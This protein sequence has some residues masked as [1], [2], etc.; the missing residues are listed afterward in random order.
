MASGVIDGLK[1]YHLNLTARQMKKSKAMVE[2]ISRII[3]QEQ[4][5]MI[6]KF[7]EKHGLDIDQ[8]ELVWQTTPRGAIIYPREKQ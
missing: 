1:N 4:D 5:Y 6:Y 8:V 3:A 7:M 2:G